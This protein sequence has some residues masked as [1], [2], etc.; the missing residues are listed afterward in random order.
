MLLERNVCGR[1]PFL[2]PV[3]LAVP[4]MPACELRDRLPVVE[5]QREAEAPVAARP[6]GTAIAEALL[7]ARTKD[8]DMIDVSLCPCSC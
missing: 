1:T 2:I 6:A 8:A 5:K 3:H 4:T 7:H